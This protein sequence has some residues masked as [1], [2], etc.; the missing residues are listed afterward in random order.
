[1]LK[2]Y[3]YTLGPDFFLVSGISGEHR[4]VGITIAP[5][6]SPPC[7][8]SPIS[9]SNVTSVIVTLPSGNASQSWHSYWSPNVSYPAGATFTYPTPL[10]TSVVF[11]RNGALVP[12]HVSTHLATVPY[13]D[14]S[15]AGAL[16]M[17]VHTPRMDGVAVSTGVRLW[18]EDGIE[19]RGEVWSAVASVV[20]CHLPLAP[21]V[22]C[23]C[24]TWARA[25]P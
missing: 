8:Q 20:P 19:V 16:T 1:V 6:L 4:G 9:D 24:R 5:S 17:L 25:P 7:V 23:R 14:A 3:T 2:D 12:L 22:R 21:P 10:T 15:W 18:K 11:V 13:A